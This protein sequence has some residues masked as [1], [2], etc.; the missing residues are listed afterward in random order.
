MLFRSE[1]E[2]RVPA[3]DLLITPGT[4]SW[5]F[6]DISTF[7][8]PMVPVSRVS[9]IADVGDA[10][11]SCQKSTAKSPTVP[12]MPDLGA[13]LY[14]RFT[15]LPPIVPEI[16]HLMGIHGPLVLGLL[17]RSTR[18]FTP[19]SLIWPENLRLLEPSSVA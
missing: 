9:G 18:T 17:C 10:T 2:P 8:W 3:K 13:L 12:V 1:T 14:V 7:A 4:I 16:W 5:F 6:L 11:F 15:V 19:T